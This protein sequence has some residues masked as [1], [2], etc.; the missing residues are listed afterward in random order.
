MPR[1][2]VTS[3]R[4]V[5]AL[6]GAA[7]LALVLPSSLGARTDTSLGQTPCELNLQCP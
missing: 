4:I 5:L 3:S 1:Y 7:L 6:T 2:A